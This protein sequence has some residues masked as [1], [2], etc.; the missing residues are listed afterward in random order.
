MLFS[1]EILMAGRWFDWVI[2][3]VFSNLADSRIFVVGIVLDKLVFIPEE[4]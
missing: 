3:K 1:G 4:G 2:L